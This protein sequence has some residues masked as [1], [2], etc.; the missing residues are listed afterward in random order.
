MTTHLP[1][2][3][4]LRGV[5]I[6]AAACLLWLPS[7]RADQPT[8]IA[9]LKKDADCNQKFACLCP[10]RDVLR[11]SDFRPISDSRVP[12]NVVLCRGQNWCDWRMVVDADGPAIFEGRIRRDP[13][14]VEDEVDPGLI[15]DEH[16]QRVVVSV[17]DGYI[18]GVDKG[19]FGGGL[20]W[21]AKDGRRS[22]RL[23]HE[24]VVEVIKT[25]A[26]A[27]ALTGL[28]HLL[29]GKGEAFAISR[30]RSA[31][32]R[33]RHLARL[34]ASAYAAT[35][36]PDGSVLVVTRTQLVS[37]DLKGKVKVLHQGKW[38]EVF[39]SIPYSDPIKGHSGDIQSDFYPGSVAALA[40]GEVLI[41]MRAVILRLLPKGNDYDEL[42][43]APS[44]CP[45]GPSSGVPPKQ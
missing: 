24:N 3:V 15:R 43:L 5:L 20:W 17:E 36:K 11:L 41:A 37:L 44:T 45:S 14:P 38:D 18:A 6:G 30:S 32:W 9:A 13:L 19:E 35:T 26:G 40:N 4:R 29:P 31:R 23:L 8:S 2:A 1:L 12:S 33:S 21:V 7:V 42:W 22:L 10:W 28:D 34:G 25:P 16:I 27:I 39:N